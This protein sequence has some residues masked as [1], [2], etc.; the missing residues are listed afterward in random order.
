[1]LFALIL[2]VFNAV[3][4]DVTGKWVAEMQGRNGQTRQVTF[5]FK[6]DGSQLTG[7]VTTNRGDAQI[8]DGKINGDEISFVQVMEFNGNQMKMT[9]KGKVSG[10]EIKFTREREGGGRT[11]EFTAK[12]AS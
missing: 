11:Q 2:F 9:Y 5:N 6:A 8:S 4:A 3:A 10:N 7:T 1:M 12:R